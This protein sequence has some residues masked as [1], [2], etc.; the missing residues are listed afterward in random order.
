M[1]A[2]TT[3]PFNNL[4]IKELNE[5]LFQAIEAPSFDPHVYIT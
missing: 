3:N 2:N 1:D 4:S 5:R